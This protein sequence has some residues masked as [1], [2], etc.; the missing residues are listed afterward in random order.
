[1]ISMILTVLFGVEL[2]LINES[3]AIVLRNED[4]GFACDSVTETNDLDGVVEALKVRL[5]DRNETSE[6]VEY[7][8]PRL[9]SIAD[10]FALEMNFLCAADST[11]KFG[12]K[13]NSNCPAHALSPLVLLKLPCN[14][15][16]LI[17]EDKTAKEQAE[18]FDG[19]SIQTEKLFDIANQCK[20]LNFPIHLDLSQSNVVK[21]FLYDVSL[22]RRHMLHDFL[23]HLQI[24]N[25]KDELDCRKK[26]V[27]ARYGQ[28]F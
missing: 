6:H 25:L 18:M 10:A 14:S 26:F 11:R 28:K 3:F 4:L 27:E 13:H 22:Q 7:A 23:L 9:R 24:A 21:K 20:D 12:P 8:T 2:L 1:M 16:T 17:L 15:R 19:G 5:L